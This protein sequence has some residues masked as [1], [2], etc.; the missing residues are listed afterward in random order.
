MKRVALE[1]AAIRVMLPD[2][3]LDV[4]PGVARVLLAILIELHEVP[5]LD[6]RQGDDHDS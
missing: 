3:P 6:R 5:V 1:D 2:E 4:T